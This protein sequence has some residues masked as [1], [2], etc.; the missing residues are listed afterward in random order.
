MQWKIQESEHL[1]NSFRGVICLVLSSEPA[2]GVQHHAYFY[3]KTTEIQRKELL[4]A[5]SSAH[6]Q[7]SKGT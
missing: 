2:V 1:H 7:A 4:R 5:P 3:E 6:Y